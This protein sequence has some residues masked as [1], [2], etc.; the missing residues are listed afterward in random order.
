MAKRI[1]L[2]ALAGAVVIFMLAGLFFGLLFAD[3]FSGQLP[4][5]FAGIQKNPPNFGVIF[6]SDLVYTSMLA[7]VFAVFAKVHTFRR[8]MAMGA[9]VGLGVVLHMDLITL[10]TTWLNTPASMALNAVLSVIMSGLGGGVIAAVQGRLG[11]TAPQA[12]A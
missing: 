9:L 4:E 12:S 6:I 5:Q 11:A 2:S 7:T 3:F 8:G 10:A 1:I